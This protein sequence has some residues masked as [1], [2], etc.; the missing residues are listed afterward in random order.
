M[1]L[2]EIF[3]KTKQNKTTETNITHHKTINKLKMSSFI[4]MICTAIKAIKQYNGGASRQAIAAYLIQNFGKTAGAHFNAS[5]RSAIKKG[6]AAG[7]LKQGDTSQ[8]FRLGEG[9]KAITNPK[10]KAKKAL[11]K[12]V[13]KKKKTTKKSKKK[14]VTKKSKKKST[15]KSKK[16]VTKRKTTK[17]SKK[18]SKK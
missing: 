14:K 16:K 15:K 9:A 5:L 4:F 1:F 2:N 3:T 18:K 7:V 13:T 6:I 8:R 12:K 11:K 17:K 10:P